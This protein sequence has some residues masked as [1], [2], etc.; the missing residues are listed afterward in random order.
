MCQVSLASAIGVSKGECN[1]QSKETP[2]VPRSGPT[3]SQCFA[4]PGD[5][6]GDGDGD[7]R[8]QG[9]TD[10]YRFAPKECAHDSKRVDSR[11]L[12]AFQINNG[13]AGIRHA[14]RLPG[15]YACAVKS[16]SL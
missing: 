7:G 3:D 14:D 6:D 1:D 16:T 8:R 11:W 13:L 4:T 10:I 12:D 15:S 9:S 5:G 2:L